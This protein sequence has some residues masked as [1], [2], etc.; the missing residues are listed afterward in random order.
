MFLACILS[1]VECFICPTQC[2]CEIK[3]IEC[4]GLILDYLSFNE[5]TSFQRLD[6][7]YNRIEGI[8]DL[9]FHWNLKN[10]PLVE[11]IDLRSLIGNK[12]IICLNIENII[13]YFPQNS[14]IEGECFK[15]VIP[16]HHVFLNNSIKYLIGFVCGIIGI[17]VMSFSMYVAIRKIQTRAYVELQEEH[18]DHDEHEGEHDEHEGEHDDH[19]GEHDESEHEEEEEERQRED[20]PPP[21]NDDRRVEPRN[22]ENTEDAE[23]EV[24]ICQ[25][26]PLSS[27]SSLSLSPHDSFA[28]EHSSSSPD[29]ISLH[30]SQHVS[31]S[32]LSSLFL[33]QLNS[34]PR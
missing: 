21:R 24:G 8:L 25:E 16:G 13:N 30:S 31:E 19:E 7:R 32:D 9:K 12:T 27:I 1:E 29:P 10:L 14:K 4:R 15:P 5:P 28:N 26:T 3:E 34:P 11:N 2:V 18:D 6:L 22:P 33:P 20:L 23:D 17:A